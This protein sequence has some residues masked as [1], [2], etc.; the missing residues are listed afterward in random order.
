M[1]AMRPAARLLGKSEHSLLSEE[2]LSMLEAGNTADPAWTARL[3]ERAP[4]PIAGF[5]EHRARA[6]MLR[7]GRLAWLL[8]LLRVTIALVWIWTGSVSLG[9]YPVELSLQL[10]ERS[11][12][13]RGLQPL[14]LYGAA[15][16]DLALG[17][18]TLLLRRRR[19]LWLG[20]SALILL[21]SAIISVRLP[22][23]WLHPY[24]PMIKNLPMLAAIYCLY[25][26]EQPRS[27]P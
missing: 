21:Y 9:L 4:R 11:G 6:A 20:Q 15:L 2:T 23:Y 3:L 10:L 17:I 19:W 7:A 25:L 1:W 8:P 22:E 16:L 13:P 12:V 14:M 26:L 5:I 24:G 18:A 27:S